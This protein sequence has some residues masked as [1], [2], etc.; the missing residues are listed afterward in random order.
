MTY[1]DLPPF[2]FAFPGPLRDQ[3]VAA[4]LSG[5]KTTTT[6]LLIE[7]ER[8]GEALPKRGE[9]AAMIDSSGAPVAV[10]ETTDVRLVPLGEIDLAHAVDEGEGYETVQAWRAGHE[11]FWHSEPMREHLNL[12]GFTVDD[13]TVAVTERFRVLSRIWPRAQVDAAVSEEAAALT[14]AL[15]AVPETTLDRPTC[16][17]PWTV[18]EEFAHTA[19]AIARTLSLLDTAVPPGEPLSVAG[20]YARFGPTASGERIAEAQLHAAKHTG[21]Q[22]IDWFDSRWREVQ[23]RVAEIAADPVIATRHGE[24]MLLC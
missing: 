6:G 18:K 16:C 1:P 17:P 15:R 8:D 5:A 23:A 10:L 9:R 11:R 21:G 20:Y 19:I 7:Y 2:E 12:P 24:P 14:Q 22:L 4:V 3:L 13:R